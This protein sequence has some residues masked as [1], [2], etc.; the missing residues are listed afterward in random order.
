MITMANLCQSCPTEMRVVRLRPSNLGLSNGTALKSART[1]FADLVGV[2]ISKT[3]PKH[4]RHVE[5]SV[6]LSHAV[7]V[8]VVQDYYERTR[9]NP[10]FLTVPLLNTQS[11]YSRA[12][13]VHLRCV[14]AKSWA[15]HTTPPTSATVK[16]QIQKW[17]E[18]NLLALG[19]PLV[20]LLSLS[21]E[22]S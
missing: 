16:L 7:E 8:L 3:P 11:E 12:W 10:S 17:Y 1:V 5:D 15:N 13:L 21:G 19:I 20:L 9:P 14:T 2:L 4:Y 22:Y 18:S 6:A